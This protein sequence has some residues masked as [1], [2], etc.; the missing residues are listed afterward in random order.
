M[1][2]KANAVLKYAIL[3]VTLLSGAGPVVAQLAGALPP[4]W[5]TVLSQIVAAAGAVH[6]LLQESP[7]TAPLLPVKA[8]LDVIDAAEAQAVKSLPKP[9]VLP[10]RIAPKDPS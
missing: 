4:Q 1:S 10:T 7:L 6:L 5:L 8:P 3:A 2:P 9:P